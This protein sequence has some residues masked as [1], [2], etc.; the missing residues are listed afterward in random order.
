MAGYKKVRNPYLKSKPGRHC[1]VYAE[2]SQTNT[3]GVYGR[4]F[5]LCTIVRDNVRGG[6]ELVILGG[7]P[8]PFSHI[9]ENLKNTSL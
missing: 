4:F 9:P 2:I 7:K 3:S 8:R 1:L 5:F 6:L